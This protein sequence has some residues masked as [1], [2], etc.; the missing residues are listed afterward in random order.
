MKGKNILV[1]VF[2]ILLAA[3]FLMAGASKLVGSE[4][5]VESFFRWG[6]GEEFRVLIGSVELLGGFALLLPRLSVLSSLGLMAV[7]LGAA[8]TH[9]AHAEGLGTAMPSMVLCVLLG[10]VAY[11]RREVLYT[12]LTLIRK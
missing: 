5:I 8:Y 11:L 9:L 3:F 2:Q 7:M 4:R 12:L 6:Y 1:W 10:V